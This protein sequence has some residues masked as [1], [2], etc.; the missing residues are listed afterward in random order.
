[1]RAALWNPFR[2]RTPEAV[3]NLVMKARVSGGCQ[4]ISSVQTYCSD[5]EPIGAW[6]ITGENSQKRTAHVRIWVE[7]KKHDGKY[8]D[9]ALY[10][11][12]QE[13]GNSW[14]V[15]STDWSDACGN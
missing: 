1:M 11:A 9:S 8:G 15:L 14:R 12:L 6:W 2:D 13:N 7:A 3:A 4:A 5:K 10:I